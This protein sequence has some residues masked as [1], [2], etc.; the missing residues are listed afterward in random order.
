[1]MDFMILDIQFKMPYNMKVF[2]IPCIF[3]NEDPFCGGKGK[4]VV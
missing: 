4:M 2:N 3:G 1:M